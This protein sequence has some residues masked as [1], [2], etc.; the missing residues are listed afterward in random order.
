MGVTEVEQAKKQFKALRVLEIRIGG[1][2]AVY[3]EDCEQI[4]EKAEALHGCD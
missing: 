3:L 4:G 2:K 1:R